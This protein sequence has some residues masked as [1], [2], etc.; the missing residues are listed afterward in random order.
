MFYN[1]NM[2]EI[3]CCLDSSINTIYEIISF[4]K[5][6]EIK[7]PSSIIDRLSKNLV[8]TIFYEKE[9]KNFF[10]WSEYSYKNVIGGIESSHRTFELIKQQMK[11]YNKN[12]IK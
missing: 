11:L 2:K 7:I 4:I 6:N 5:E 1:R 10:G 3:I 9:S 12:Q 8:V